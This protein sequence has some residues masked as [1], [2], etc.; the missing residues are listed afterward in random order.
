MVFPWRSKW[1]SDKGIFS[2]VRTL[3]QTSLKISQ[4]RSSRQ[5]VAPGGKKTPGMDHVFDEKGRQDLGLEPSVAGR[6]GCFW[7]MTDGKQLFES[8]EREFHLPAS[9]I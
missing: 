1:R 7:D 3:S 8:L 6:I 9:A 4:R 2:T 5:P